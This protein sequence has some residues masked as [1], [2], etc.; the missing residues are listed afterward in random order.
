M[1]WTK[2]RSLKLSKVCI[3]GF[4][5]LLFCLDADALWLALGA[6]FGFGGAWADTLQV[7]QGLRI[8]LYCTVAA[9]GSPLAWITLYKLWRL[10]GSISRRQVF[11]P[12]NVSIM[13]TVSWCCFGAAAV[14]FAGGIGYIPLFVL[15]GAAAFMGLI[16]RVVKNIF[17]E[18]I[19]MKDELDL[20]I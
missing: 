11:V 1:N 7:P 8:W 13:R 12:D 9:A 4:A 19:S 17:Q 20:T 10:V 16:V 3:V 6:A 14:C 18:A 15:A 5:L 2:D